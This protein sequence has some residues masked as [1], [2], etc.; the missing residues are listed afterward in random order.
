MH[1][2]TDSANL[3]RP[4]CHNNFFFGYNV[5]VQSFYPELV[6]VHKVST[7]L[8]AIQTMTD[9][10]NKGASDAKGP[11]RKDS[12]KES[13]CPFSTRLDTQPLHLNLSLC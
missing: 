2:G 9:R 4:G 3:R 11:L 12:D 7:L 5:L 13:Q 10:A 6:D 1:R 8:S